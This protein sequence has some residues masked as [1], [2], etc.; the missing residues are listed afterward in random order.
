MLLNYWPFWS[1][2]RVPLSGSCLEAS[3]RKH[4]GQC[5]VQLL[6]LPLLCLHHCVS[7]IRVFSGVLGHWARHDRG[8]SSQSPSV[9]EGARVISCCHVL[10]VLRANVIGSLWKGPNESSTFIVCTDTR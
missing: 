5:S 9:K 6:G 10:N 3:S 7:R 1:T 2:S 8:R 4:Q